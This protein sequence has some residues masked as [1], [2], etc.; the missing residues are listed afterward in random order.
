M[1]QAVV[2]NELPMEE[3]FPL[4]AADREPVHL[5]VVQS[6]RTEPLSKCVEDALRIYLR[7]T[8]GHGVTN[9]HQFVIS[10]IERPMLETVMQ[11][12]EG[13]LSQAA[14]IL[15]LTRSTLRKRLT[16]Y[17]IGRGR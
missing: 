6:G 3:P 1:K 5:E 12:T 14:K 11:H 17:G 13:N 16:E 4:Q 7:T 15:G 8:D 9:L 10:E 2:H